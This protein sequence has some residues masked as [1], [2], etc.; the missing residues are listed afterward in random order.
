MPPTIAEQEQS[1]LEELKLV[2]QEENAEQV[3]SEKL[4][5]EVDPVPDTEETEEVEESEEE[6]EVETE[7]SEEDDTE[8]EDG[9]ESEEDEAPEEENLTGAKFRHKLKAEKEAR[10]TLQREAQELKERLAHLEGKAE[11]QIPQAAPQAEEIPDREYEPEKYAIWRAEKLEEKMKVIEAS[12]AQSNAERQWEVMQSDHSRGNPTYTDAKKFLLD[13]ETTKIRQV[14]PGATDAQIS[15]HLKEQEYLEVSKAAQAGMDPLQHIEF[16]AYKSG[17]RPEAAK[18]EVG[19]PKKKSNIAK[20]KKN[21]K[22]NVS[23]IGGSGAAE[24]GNK[25]SA[26]QLLAMS[27]KDIEKFGRTNFEHALTTLSQE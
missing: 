20:I 23:L 26:D 14:Y 24:S 3:S 6:Q 1:I 9:D 22:K 19:A 12:Q 4:L 8:N 13:Q 15:Q 27:L 2:A 16:L 17:F 11:A 21:A 18:K 25:L 7:D 10:E 5:N